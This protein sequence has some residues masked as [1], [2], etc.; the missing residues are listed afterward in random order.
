[1]NK[2][3]NYGKWRHPKKRSEFI[4]KAEENLPEINLKMDERVIES[5]IVYVPWVMV[6]PPYMIFSDKNGTRKIWI[7]NKRK[8]I[9]YYLYNL[10]NIKWFLK[11]YNEQGR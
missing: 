7:K 8:I 4:N 11:K 9:L 2:W 6:N 3:S 10:T 5:K 1:M